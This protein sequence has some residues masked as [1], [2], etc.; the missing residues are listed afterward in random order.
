MRY[1]NLILKP[2]ISCFIL[3]LWLWS[4][5]SGRRR[6]CAEWSTKKNDETELQV[7][8]TPIEVT[9]QKQRKPEAREAGTNCCT[10]LQSRT[11]LSGSGTPMAILITSTIFERS[12]LLISKWSLL[13]LS[14]DLWLCG[15]V[16]FSVVAECN[17]CT[18]N[19]LLCCL[20]WRKK[21]RK[22]ERNYKPGGWN[23]RD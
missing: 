21:K 2:M 20:N 17:A 18:V 22:R 16:F 7:N 1:L 4:V 11:C 8:C 12:T 23:D 9:E 15:Q 13:V 3:C 19:H 10:S 5:A 14:P 6:E